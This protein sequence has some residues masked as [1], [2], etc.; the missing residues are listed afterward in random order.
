MDGFWRV[1]FRLQYRLL[2]W[3]DPLIRATWRRFGMGNVV[4]VDVDRRKGKGVRSR[5]LGVLNSGGSSY[6]GHPSGAVGWTRDLQAAGF[7][8]MRWRNGGEWRFRATL[9]PHGAERERAI[10]ATDQHP[11]PGNLA[12]RL[13]RGHIRREGVFFRLEDA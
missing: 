10:R 13:G 7:G 1:A 12:Y 4:E 3:M 9:L 6:L 2:A 11:F 8:V 5:L